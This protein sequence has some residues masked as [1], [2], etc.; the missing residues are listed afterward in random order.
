M[1]VRVRV[2]ITRDDKEVETSALA[3]SGY[4]S[5]T[6]Q[7]LAP[8]KVAELL[9]LWPP[10]KNAEETI[11]E[12]AGGP[13]RVWIISKGVKVKVMTSDVDTEYVDA[14]LVISPIADEVL[15]SDK[16]ISELKI[17][18]EDVGRGFWRFT[19]EPKEKIRRS[20]PPKYWKL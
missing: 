12:T 14:D 9:S 19:W 10:T 6:P 3:N 15:L 20:E 1:V 13:L 17:A 11:F 7:I 2:R 18:L 5:E 16:M 8:I 4:E